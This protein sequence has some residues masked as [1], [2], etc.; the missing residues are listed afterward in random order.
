MEDLAENCRDST[1]GT[2]DQID[3]QEDENGTEPPG[4]VHVKK[5]K[6]VQYIIEISSVSLNI[7]RTRC[8]L[9][10]NGSNN[11]ENSK[12]DKETDGEFEGT[13]KVEED[14]KKPLFLSADLFFWFFHGL[15]IQERKFKNIL[16]LPLLLFREK[17]LLGACREV[18]E[19]SNINSR[20]L[21]SIPA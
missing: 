15:L 3:Y 16:L 8:I 14:I 17:K 10:D 13:E 11:G 9:L 18:I 12:Q 21:S 4:M 7:F 20:L 5:V 1:D 6:K 2:G 19:I